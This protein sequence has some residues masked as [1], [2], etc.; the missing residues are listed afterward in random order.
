MCRNNQELLEVTFAGERAGDHGFNSRTTGRSLIKRWNCTRSTSFQIKGETSETVHIEKSSEVTNNTVELRDSLFLKYE[1]NNDKMTSADRYTCRR[2]SSLRY[3]LT[4]RPSSRC[5]SNR[6]KILVT[7][8]K[9][10]DLLAP[11]V[12]DFRRRV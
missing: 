2:T 7:G 10:V 3:T 8:I 4:L 1:K 11:Y 5:Q 6:K 12:K 9:V